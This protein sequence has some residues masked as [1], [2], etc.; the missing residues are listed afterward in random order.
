MFS[1]MPRPFAELVAA[2]AFSF[3]QGASRAE[4]MVVAAAA[5]GLSALGIADRNSV[6]GVV[7]AHVAAEKLGLRIVPGARL[8][9]R[10]S[11]TELAVYPT[12]RAAWGR[13]TQL[14]SLGKMRAAK[15][16]CDLALA[17]ALAHA[18]GL[19]AVAIRPEPGT[20]GALR[21]A[22]GDRLYLAATV[23]YLDDDARRLRA[24][25]ELGQ[26][27]GAP[28]LATADALYHTPA[29][30]ILHDTMTAIRLGT[31]VEN[32][33]TALLANGERHLKSPDEM[34]RL[35]RALPQALAANKEEWAA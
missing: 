25:A 15:G 35:F 7:R 23:F 28:L 12:S 3:L 13:L 16:G 4:E 30:R 2:T 10:D 6:A 19:L 18:E 20:I 31:T 29:R 14:L 32:A 26:R 22:F 27:H 17:D 24:L 34:A 11:G 33:G 9:L 8:A 1:L 5:L 21:E